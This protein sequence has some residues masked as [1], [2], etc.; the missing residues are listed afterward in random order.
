MTEIFVDIQEM[1]PEAIGDA[2]WMDQELKL[3]IYENMK[4]FGGSFVKT[5]AELM[6]RSDKK[7]LERIAMVFSEYLIS[8]RPQAWRQ[9]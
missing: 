2:L 8:Y 1:T 6:I 3:R 4:R 9:K 7:N 5:L